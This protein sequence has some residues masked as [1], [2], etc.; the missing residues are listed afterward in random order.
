MLQA[1]TEDDPECAL[2]LEKKKILVSK[3]LCFLA[4]RPHDHS[5]ARHGLDKYE[6]DINY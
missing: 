2:H 4:M 1:L 5:F 6:Y 3:Q